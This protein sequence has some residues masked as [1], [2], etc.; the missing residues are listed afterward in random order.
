MSWVN[1]RPRRKARFPRCRTLLRL[2]PVVAG[3]PGEPRGSDDAF[4]CQ[5]VHLEWKSIVALTAQDCR[6][7]KRPCYNKDK[8]KDVPEYVSSHV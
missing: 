2:L 1:S 3:H 7:V 8:S 5:L 6:N 4:Q